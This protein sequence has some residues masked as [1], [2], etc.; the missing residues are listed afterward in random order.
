MAPPWLSIVILSW[1]H[2]HDILVQGPV[3]CMQRNVVESKASIDD[4]RC[5]IGVVEH[6]SKVLQAAELAFQHGDTPLH[7][8]V[9]GCVL[10]VVSA[11]GSVAR[12]TAKDWN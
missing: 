4:L 8:I 7:N 12:L 1:W 10:L 6:R 3:A 9:H 5:P 2:V 11:F